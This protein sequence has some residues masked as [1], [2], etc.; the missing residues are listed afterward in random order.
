[1]THTVSIAS[2]GQI[3]IPAAF[4]RELGLHKYARAN[5]RVEGG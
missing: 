4:R 5:V 3:T 2:Q 1:M